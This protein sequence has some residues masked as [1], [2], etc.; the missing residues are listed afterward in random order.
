MDEK[1]LA[2]ARQLLHLVS[3]ELK[4]A[5]EAADAAAAASA[6]DDREAAWSKVQLL[7]ARFDEAGQLLRDLR[8][9]VDA[10]L[11]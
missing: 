5:S 7:Y 2:E 11:R 9:S 4:Q 3:L 10:A 8:R 6:S 1:K